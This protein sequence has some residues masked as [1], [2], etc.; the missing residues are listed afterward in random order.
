MI[1]LVTHILANMAHAVRRISRI[2]HGQQIAVFGVKHKQQA[3]Q[4]HQRGFAHLVEVGGRELRALELAIAGLMRLRLQITPGQRIG[5]LRKDVLEHASAQVL[6]D[7]FFVNPRFVQCKGMKAAARVVPRLWQKRLA[8]EEEIKQPQR[9]LMFNVVQLRLN[10][11]HAQRC[12]QVHLKKFLGPRTRVLPVKPPHRAVGQQAPFDGP[13]RHHFGA[14]QVAQ[15]LRRWR[16]GVGAF[17][18]VAAVERAQPAL[19]LQNRQAV[20]VTAVV[21]GLGQRL[22]LGGCIGKQQ[23]VGNVFAALARQIDLRQRV[24]APAECQQNLLN[25]HLLGLGFVDGR[26]SA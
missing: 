5:E 25:H 17:A 2:A 6:R 14:A 19:G 1:K 16:V 3:V 15:H 13:V 8:L 20:R 9:V 4:Q 7:F 11:L 22:R 23:H 18:A 24:V 26:V 10:P 21:F 12:G